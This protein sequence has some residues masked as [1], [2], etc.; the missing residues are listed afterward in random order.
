[1]V[2]RQAALIYALEGRP[3]DCN[4]I[5]EGYALMKES[6]GV[7]SMFRGYSSIGIAAMLS[8]KVDRQR[9]FDRT[10][11][12]YEML[13]EA[14]F[15]RSEYLAVA[16]YMIAV[17]A[18]PENYQKTVE[19]TKAFYDGMKDKNWF[20]TGQNDYIM[21]AMLALSD[22]DVEKGVSE[23]E[24][25]Y[26]Q[27]KSEF[28]SRESVQILAQ[29]MVVGGITGQAADRVIALKNA[30]RDQNMPMHREYTL[31]A[32]G[33]L[34][35][36]PIDVNTIVQEVKEA[37]THLKGQKGFGPLSVK[38]QE[39]LLYATAITASGY[40]EDVQSGLVKAAVSTSIINLIIAMQ[41]AMI[42]AVIVASNVVVT[43]TG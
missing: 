39:L 32:L 31:P 37:Q 8:L 17:N 33:I 25:L 14:K 23:I 26:Q 29:T 27:L 6:T 5:N 28:F 38:K 30:F 16:S 3:I 1:M 18:E 21:A 36:L 13:K 34:A 11:S 15:W 10:V 4:A 24:V 9:I 19:R 2:K 43:S 41:M 35:L 20:Y 7:L 40:A 22:A 12:I 42:V